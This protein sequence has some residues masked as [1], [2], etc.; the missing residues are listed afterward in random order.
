MREE[1]FITEAEEAR[2]SARAFGSVRI[3]A[4]PIR[5]PATR[6]SSC[7][8]CSA[9]VRR[10]PSARLGS[11]DD[12]RPGAAGRGGAG[13]RD[14]LRAVRR[15]GAPGGARRID[16]RTGDILALVG[17]RDFPQSQFNRAARSRRQPGS[18]FKPLLYAAA[19][20]NGYSPVSVIDGLRHIEPQGPEEWSP[21]NAN[22]ETPDALTLRA[23]LLESNNRAATA[24]QQR[25]ARGRCCGS[26]R[27]WARATCP[28]CR[29]CRSAP[30]S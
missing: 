14:G 23:A 21:R 10:R 6:R 11:A 13:G 17:G 4:P 29:H 18:A 28:T 8:S 3:P 24:L 19:L 22:G 2:R 27:T 20:E 30:A 7:A 9:T 1:G 12:F 5:A 16:P 15:A 25:W 26:R